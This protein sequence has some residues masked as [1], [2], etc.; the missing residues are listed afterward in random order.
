MTNRRPIRLALLTAVVLLGSAGSTRAADPVASTVVTPP[1]PPNTAVG[2]NIGL[3]SA[4]GLAGLTLTRAV[5]HFI[6]LEV[7][8]GYGVSGYQLSLM[9][10][11]ALGAP[12]DHFVAGAGVSVAFPTDSRLSSGHPVWLNLDL[13]GFE[14]RF[15]SGIALST[16]AG[17]SG[18][19]GGGKLCFPPDGCEP[20]FQ[21]PVTHFWFPQV[22]AGLAYWF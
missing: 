19:L 9:P 5:G 13:V 15:D 22:R 16:A 2:V 14:H 21:E 6:R 12:N 20:E 11:I 8:G 1:P 3:G 7:G 4:V 18:G 17:L 10:K